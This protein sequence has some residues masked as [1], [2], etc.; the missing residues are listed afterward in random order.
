[1]WSYHFYDDA[2]ARRALAEVIAQ[3]NFTTVLARGGTPQT[4][5]FWE[6]HRFLGEVQGYHVYRVEGPRGDSSP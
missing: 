3:E 5:T 4:L 1:M 6:R 2:E